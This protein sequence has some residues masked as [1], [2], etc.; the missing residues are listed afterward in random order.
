MRL[1]AL[2]GDIRALMAQIRLVAP[3]TALARAQGHELQLRSFHDC[4]RADLAACDVL[5]VQRGDSARV[6]RQQQIA[7]L[8][9]A[10]VVYEIDDLLTEIAPHISNQAAVRARQAALRR[11]MAQADAVSVATVRLGRELGLADAVLVPN[12]AFALGD[13][14]LP[15]AD[16]SQP[17]TLLFA[18]SDRLAADFI[19]PALRALA[20]ARVVVVGP[21]GEAFEAEGI[22]VQRHPLMP[23]ERFVGF[24][25][26]LVNPLAVIPLEDSRFAA[27]KSAVKWF[28]YAEA[29][30]PTLCSAV[31][32]YLEVIEPGVTG[33]LVKNDDQAWR[34][35]LQT[36]IG[37]AAWRQRVAVAARAVV[38]ERHTMAQTVAG[39]QRA[40]DAALERRA[41]LPPAAPGWAWQLREALAGRIEGASLRLRA[42]NRARLAK[43][44]RR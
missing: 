42:F 22:A 10:A 28:D 40:I 12:Q 6:L 27:C 41:A 4:T 11:C 2:A 20:G 13:V 16:A 17:V 43:R 21:P 34:G 30:I 38:R 25:R 19:Y 7:R 26:A 39:W 1:L 14:P 5:V 15:V 8:H 37:D 35:A 3:L 9:G 32:P 18:S 29:G 23:R 36:A 24:A 31:S 33:A 44:P